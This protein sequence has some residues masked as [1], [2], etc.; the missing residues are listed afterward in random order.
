MSSIAWNLWA[1]ILDRLRLGFA[2][3]GVE[4]PM[5]LG[6]VGGLIALVAGVLFVKRRW[7]LA[8]SAI[9]VAILLC[10]VVLAL[11]IFHTPRTLGT[12]LP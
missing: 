5:L 10:S 8:L 11:G 3:A 4:I 6:V 7:G 9:T 12:E 2:F 1:L